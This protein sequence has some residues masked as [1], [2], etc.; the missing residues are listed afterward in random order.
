MAESFGL[1]TIYDQTLASN[2][3]SAKR[4]YEINIE[5]YSI[6]DSASYSNPE[7]IKTINIDPFSTGMIF[8]TLFDFQ[9]TETTTANTFIGINPIGFIPNMNKF[10]I[11]IYRSKEASF[12]HTAN[13]AYCN[14]KFASTSNELLIYGYDTT[15]KTG[16][17]WLQGLILILS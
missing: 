7:L 11:P 14:V 4:S 15:F 13:S 5:G 3:I 17:L 12:I 8:I 6:S 16:Y 9:G 2:L 1:T 10:V